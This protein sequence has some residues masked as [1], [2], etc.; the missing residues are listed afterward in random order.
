LTRAS[1]ATFRY[2]KTRNFEFTDVGH[3]THGRSPYHGTCDRPA[4]Q[5]PSVYLGQVKFGSTRCLPRRAI[6]PTTPIVRHQ[7]AWRPGLVAGRDALRLRIA[8]SGGGQ[9][10]LIGSIVLNLSSGT[11]YWSRLLQN[12]CLAVETRGARGRGLAGI[13]RL[14]TPLSERFVMCRDLQGAIA[15]LSSSKASSQRERK[16]YSIIVISIEARTNFLQLSLWHRRD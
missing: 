10:S 4:C 9:G 13:T 6:G 1:K 8:I 7:R 15:V 3:Q 12:R 5:K 14:R 2:S 16:L 11:G